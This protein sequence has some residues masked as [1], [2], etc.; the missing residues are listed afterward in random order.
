MRSV[1]QGCHS[2]NLDDRGIR[3]INSSVRFF[4]RS[5][6]IALLD[7]AHVR[8]IPAMTEVTP[9]GHTYL[10]LGSLIDISSEEWLADDFESEEVCGKHARRYRCIYVAICTKS[11][12]FIYLAPLKTHHPLVSDAVCIQLN[13][14]CLCC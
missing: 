7:G 1:R 2:Q 3:E 12:L 6:R 4:A 11:N 8:G 5:D 13:G 9:P 14:L 10:G